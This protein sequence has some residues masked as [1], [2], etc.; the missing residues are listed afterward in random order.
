VCVSVFV[1]CVCLSSFLFVSLQPYSRLRVR[2]SVDVDA[3]KRL[4]EGITVRGVHYGRIDATL[5]G[6]Q[7]TGTSTTSCFV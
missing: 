7:Q 2:G 4:R 6:G 1:L 5:L 3:L